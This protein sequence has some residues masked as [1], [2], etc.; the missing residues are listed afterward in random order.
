[1]WQ[2]RWNPVIVWFFRMTRKGSP[3]DE[4]NW[5]AA[6]MNWLLNRNGL[7]GTGSSWARSF[8]DDAIA[9]ATT[10]RRRAM[11]WC[12]G[13]RTI[14]SRGT[15]VCSSRTTRANKRVKILGGNHNTASGHRRIGAAWYSYGPGKGYTLLSYRA[16]SGFKPLPAGTSPAGR[17]RVPGLHGR[18]GPLTSIVAAEVRVLRRAGAPPRCGR[19]SGLRPLARV[20]SAPPPIGVRLP[21]AMPRP[22]DPHPVRH[23]LRPC[24]RRPR[25][26][27]QE[28]RRRHPARRAAWCSP[29]CR[30]RA[31]PRWPSARST[32]RRSA[33]TSNRSPP[34]RGA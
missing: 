30:A 7:Q 2:D 10:T 28:R 29:G 3:D 32:P 15:S 11:S 4:T 23:A 31:S 27:P 33:A 19:A 6:Y 9:P 22:D 18:D 24:A 1:M 13:A 8:H 34:M 25:A 26:Q 12:S 14:R 17:P 20:T 5:C 16:M 21:P